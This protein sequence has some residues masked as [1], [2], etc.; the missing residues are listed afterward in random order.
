MLFLPGTLVIYNRHF[1]HCDCG[2][3]KEMDGSAACVEPQ[4]D[5]QSPSEDIILLMGLA[6]VS[7]RLFVN[8]MV[9]VHHHNGG[10]HV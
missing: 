10:A 8:V 6:R 3:I 4:S 5:T 1:V 9:S 7:V 2:L